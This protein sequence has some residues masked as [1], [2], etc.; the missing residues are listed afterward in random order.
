MK[1]LMTLIVLLMI[2]GTASAALLLYDDFDYTVDENLDD[3]TLWDGLGATTEEAIIASGSLSYTGLEPSAGNQAQLYGS[4]SGNSGTAKQITYDATGRVA[5]EALYVSFLLNVTDV[6]TLSTSNSR[7]LCYYRLSVYNGIAIRQHTGASDKFD[8]AVGKQVD[9]SPQSIVWDDNGG[10]G[11]NEGDTILI[12]Y[13]VDNVD[14]TPDSDLKCWINP[15]SLGDTA[16]TA[17]MITDHKD[18]SGAQLDDFYFGC[19]NGATVYVDE[20]RIGESFADV[21]PAEVIPVSGTVFIME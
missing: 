5:G 8:I 9:D 19:G 4:V 18:G 16:P 7:F 3:Q 12:V 20:L 6:G 11:Y 17:T 10:S 15:S 14:N 13:G 1:K 2:A 21:T